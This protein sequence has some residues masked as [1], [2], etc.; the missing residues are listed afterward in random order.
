[1]I[2]FSFSGHG[3]LDLA[4]YNAYLRG[5]LKDYELSIEELKK[6]FFEVR[7]MA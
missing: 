1:M 7:G 6:S 4:S 2:L 3:L 5:E